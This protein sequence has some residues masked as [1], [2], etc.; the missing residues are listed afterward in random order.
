M[1]EPA[2]G[3]TT[4][5]TSRRT[6]RKVLVANRG[7]IAVRVLRTLRELGMRGAVA[8]SDA[9]RKSL[10]VLMA[11]EAYRIGPPP[12]RES[13]LR[14]DA[15]VALAVDI[16]ADAIHPGYGF[17]SEN[18]RFA[19][20]C[21]QAGV[22]LIGPPAAAI[23]A[24]GS[25][26]ES[27]RLMQQAGVPTVP[28]GHDPLP[29]LAVAERAAAAIGY[30]VMLK[31]AAGGGGKGMRLIGSA[32]ELGAA[33]RG[34]RSEAAASFGDDAVYLE[35]Y[36]ERPRHVEIQ[37]IG[38]RHGTLVSLGE[39][40]CSLQR[41]HQKVVEEAPSTAV[42]PALRAAMGEAA[43]KAARA[44]GYW[45]AGTVEFLLGADG[46]FYF[47]EM[48]TRLQVEHPVTELVTGLD[49][50]RAQIDVAQGEPLPPSFHGVVPRGHAIEV[51]LYAEDP[52]RNYAPSPGRIELL[53]WPQGPGVRNDVGVY[54]GC[55]VSIHYDP[56]LGKLIVWGADRQQALERLARALDELRLEG[57]A[58]NIPL[59]Q[60]LLADEQFRRGDLD[61]AMLD[62][63]LK[64]GELVL[65]TPAVDRD[66]PFVAAALAELEHSRRAVGAAQPRRGA[67]PR[68]SEAARR[69]ALRGGSWS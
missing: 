42:S 26:I 20:L 10:A 47:L 23:A 11:D 13:Y 33:Y 14:A 67:R 7:E 44:V 59:F 64:A 15:L 57:V 48:N 16:G 32:G 66:L 68:W 46:S 22:E 28:G 45:N 69:L 53:R 55:E 29:D 65:P 63:K 30:P 51:R 5:R 49:L 35:K 43:V 1:P 18:A 17:L 61:I 31:A 34:A 40:E 24:M 38:D 39:R 27:R 19:E 8:Y 2:Q 56:M 52:Y 3:I 54:E 9:D 58:T 37:V 62:R 21:E 60:A 4:R 12:S 36:L 25:K 50:V 6:F 41:R